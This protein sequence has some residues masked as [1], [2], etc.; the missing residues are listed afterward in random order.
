MSKYLLMVN[1][2][3]TVD[4][5]NLPRA[6]CNVCGKTTLSS[7]SRLG[8][9][10][11]AEKPIPAEYMQLLADSGITINESHAGERATFFKYLRDARRHMPDRLNSI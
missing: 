3:T 4:L 11:E 6:L 7:A 5:I 9:Q 8:Y 10:L 1:P 2:Y